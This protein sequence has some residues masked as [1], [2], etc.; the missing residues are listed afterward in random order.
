MSTEATNWVLND[1]PG[2][3]AHAFGVLVGLANHADKY[4]RGAYPSQQTLADYARKSVRQVRRDLGD[5]KAAG[6]IREGDFRIVAHLPADERPLVWDLAMELVRPETKRTGHAR[7]AVGD[8]AD[9]HDRAD[10]DVRSKSESADETPNSEERD[11]T[12][13]TGGTSTSA[14]TSTSDK[15]KTNSSS[16]KKR[17]TSDRKQAEPPPEHPLFAE[18]WKAYPRREGK[19]KAREAFANAVT[20]GAK[21]EILVSAAARYASYN[22]RAK[23]ELKYIAHPTTWLNQERWEDDYGNGAG[24]GGQPPPA[25][26][27]HCGLCDL[28]DRT[29]ELPDGAIAYCPDC[30]PNAERNR[31]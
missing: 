18:F 29:V 16:S 25:L 17:Y 30:H 9:V 20:N 31:Q 28:P 13:A 24:S 14:R 10:T 15:P 7:P 1:A 22:T 11:R 12:P 26:P 21:P 27:P 3:P 2:L 6:L 5:L 23:T 19:A 8:R 4:G